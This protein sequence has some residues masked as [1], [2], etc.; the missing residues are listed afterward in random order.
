MT[1]RTPRPERFNINLHTSGRPR[2]LTDERDWTE[3]AVCAGTDLE[4]FFPAPGSHGAQA[5]AVCFGCPV[6]EDCIL[7]ALSAPWLDGVWAATTRPER[8]RLRTTLHTDL[9]TEEQLRAFA[10]RFAG[11]VHA[12]IDFEPDPEPDPDQED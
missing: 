6:I 9:L 5:K 1:S 8:A 7:D 2:R 12:R 11:Y 3:S 4:L 10:A